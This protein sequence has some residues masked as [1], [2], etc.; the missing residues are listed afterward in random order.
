[1]AA[2]GLRISPTMSTNS[3][4]I[5]AMKSRREKVSQP[6]LVLPYPPDDWWT[7]RRSGRIREPEIATVKAVQ[8]AN[9]EMESYDVEFL[10][11]AYRS[12][13]R[14]NLDKI[15]MERAARMNAKVIHDK[16]VV[17]A[18]TAGQMK[19]QIDANDRK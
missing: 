3:K 12:Y 9:S 4:R 1:V 7:F 16:T 15:C 6:K 19:E 10:V 18:P 2:N 17:I 5:R 8:R 14:K 11:K 13:K